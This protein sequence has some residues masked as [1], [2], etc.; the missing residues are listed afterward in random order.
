MA[1]R[2]RGLSVNLLCPPPPL[3][4]SYP[5]SAMPHYNIMCI[6][7]RT[8]PISHLVSLFSRLTP[9]SAAAAAATSTATTTTATTPATTSALLTSI[10]HLGLRPLAYRMKAHQRYNLEGRYIQLGVLASPQ[11]LN[12]I[13]RKLRVDEEI[14]RFLTTKQPPPSPPAASSS[15]SSSDVVAGQVKF[16][17]PYILSQLQRSTS[18]DCYAARALLDSGLMTE[19]D[20]MA[21]D[22]RQHDPDWEQRTAAVRQ[23]RE[24]QRLQAEEAEAKAVA[25][26]DAK[27]RA[28][29]DEAYNNAKLYL[30]ERR[31]QVVVAN[32]AR[33]EWRQVENVRAE[34]RKAVI[35]QRLLDKWI[36][37]EMKARRAKRKRRGELRWTTEEEA[38]VE[39]SVR[40]MFERQRESRRQRMKRLS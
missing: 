18:I 32:A 5:L 27:V 30:D 16:L 3:T 11:A 31:K 39:A 35:E 29:V 10:T 25:E 37:K 17:D 7:S 12:D 34:Q 23:Q 13:E 38:A 40:R 6:T 15:S 19:H 1:C 20:V 24:Q 36:S 21:L 9:A 8:A 22:R 28:R 14:I 33:V 26:A 2:S 4:P